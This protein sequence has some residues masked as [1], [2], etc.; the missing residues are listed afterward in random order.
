MS[1]NR[2]LLFERRCGKMKKILSSFVLFILALSVALLFGPLEIGEVLP[3][4]Q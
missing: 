1:K 4:T 3:V 2:Q